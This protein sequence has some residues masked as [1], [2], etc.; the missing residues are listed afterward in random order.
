MIKVKINI[1]KLKEKVNSLKRKNHKELMKMIKEQVT[2][3]V[4]QFV[5][6]LLE[7]E[8]TIFLG[9]ERYQRTGGQ[10]QKNYRNGYHRQRQFV[11]KGI[12]G[13]RVKVPRDRLGRF[14]SR[15]IPKGKRYDEGTEE[16]LQ[17]LFLAGVSTR[18]AGEIAKEILGRSFSGAEVSEAVQR[19]TEEM[20]AWRQRRLDWKRYIYLYCDGVNFTI[21]R[22]RDITKES[23]LVVIGV[24]EDGTKD[25]LTFEA[26]DKETATHWEAVFHSLIERGL[27]HREVQLG[28]MDGLVGLE[29]VFKETFPNAQI[30]RCQVHKAKNVLCRVPR[31]YRKEFARWMR[32]VFYAESKIEAKEN[33]KKLEEKW[34]NIVPVAVE[35]LKKDVDRCLTYLDFP[36][37]HWISL[38]TTNAIERLHKEYKRRTKPMEIAAGEYSLYRILYY[39][40]RRMEETWKVF[41]IGKVGRNISDFQ[42]NKFTQIA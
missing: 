2:E 31:R 11:I 33:M 36:R 17:K 19:L 20:K 10:T 4:T 40:S 7:A 38:R 3:K 35:C 34:I 39:V 5:N 32:A 12:G 29:R 16:I 42:I 9:R 37:E 27:R 23:V 21:R 22:G 26:G 28:I 13:I 25:V 24:A 30:Q 41:R 8:I 1:K 6:A 15:I 14:N 18:K